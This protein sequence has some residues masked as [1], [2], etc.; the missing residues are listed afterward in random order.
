M[1]HV[2][3]SR[4]ALYQFATTPDNHRNELTTTPPEKKAT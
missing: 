1:C 3:R 2:E 4:D